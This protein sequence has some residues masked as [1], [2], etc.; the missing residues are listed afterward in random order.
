MP[1]Y[2][3]RL[4]DDVP[5]LARPLKVVV[6]AGSGVGGPVAPPIFRQL[7]CQVWEIACVPDAN[8]PFHHPDPTVPGNLEILFDRGIQEKAH[9]GIAYD[10][11]P[12][13]TGAVVEKATTWGAAKLRGF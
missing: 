3:E 4:L 7:G 12:D 5:N 13:R 10:A 1:S 11:D 2:H 6:D 8:F 9:L